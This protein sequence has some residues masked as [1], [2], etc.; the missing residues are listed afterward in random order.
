MESAA[1]NASRLSLS[2]E[3]ERPRRN[4]VACWIAH[5]QAAEVDDGAQVAVV[6]Q[7]VAGM[8]VAMDP[9]GRP[10]PRRCVRGLRPRPRSPHRCR[11]SCATLRWRRACRRLGLPEERRGQSCVRRDAARRW[12]R[13]AASAAMNCASAIAAWRRSAKRS[14]I[15]FSPGSHRQ[16]DQCQG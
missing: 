2:L 9:D 12:H 3:K 11:A 14:T 16:T 10:V 15:A 5:A 4:K 8:E 7:Q 1:R 13:F 6:N